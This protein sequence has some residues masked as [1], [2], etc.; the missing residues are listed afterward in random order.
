MK[1][2]RRSPPGQRSSNFK[3]LKAKK[4]LVWEPKESESVVNIVPKVLVRLKVYE[5]RQE[6][7]GLGPDKATKENFFF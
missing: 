2:W 7:H 4:S 6:P 3:G 1:T 5:I